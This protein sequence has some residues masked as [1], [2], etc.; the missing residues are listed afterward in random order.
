MVIHWIMWVA[1]FKEL[2]CCDNASISSEVAKLKKKKKKKINLATNPPKLCL[3]KAAKLQKNLTLSY[4]GLL[5]IAAHCSSKLK[6][7]N[8]ILM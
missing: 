8:N 7:K 6:T 1:N 4:S 5:S 2:L 3:S